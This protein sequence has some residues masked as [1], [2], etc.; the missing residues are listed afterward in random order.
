[1]HPVSSAAGANI[2]QIMAFRRIPRQRRASSFS[3]SY[4]LRCSWNFCITRRLNRMRQRT[5]ER[6]CALPRFPSLLSSPCRSPFLPAA[7]TPDCDLVRPR[8]WERWQDPSGH[9]SAVSAIRR[10]IIGAAQRMLRW[11][12]AAPA[13]RAWNGELRSARIDLRRARRPRRRQ[14]HLL[15]AR[16][17]SLPS[18]RQLYLP[19]RRRRYLPSGRRHYLQSGRQRYFGPMPRAISSNTY[20]CRRATTAF[21]RTA[22][23]PSCKARLRRRTSMI[24]A[25]HAIA[26]QPTKSAMQPRR[27]R[28]PSPPPTSAAMLQQ[29][30]APMR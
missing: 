21:G 2:S 5:G 22:T 3:D 18:R 14:R 7:R 11:A 29:R 16:R 13:P 27:Q 25:V 12:R 23:T 15:S 24:G 26:R 17:R 4:L 19:I 8:C 10:G 28:R 20:S 1:M 6:S 30:P 9:C